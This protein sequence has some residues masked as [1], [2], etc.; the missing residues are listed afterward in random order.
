MTDND[1]A[2][3]LLR[4]AAPPAATRKAISCLEALGAEIGK[5][6]W[7]ARLQTG[8]GRIPC[9]HVQNPEP[10]AGALAENIYA[11]PKDD[12]WWFWWSWAE[13]IAQDITATATIIRRTLRTA[14]PQP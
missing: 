10:G 4:P 6:G 13:P 8:A 2:S 1:H 9:L 3:A 12:S 7:I 5:T 11:A 14:A